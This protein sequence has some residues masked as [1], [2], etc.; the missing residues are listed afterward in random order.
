[1]KQMRVQVRQEQDRVERLED[2]V[3]LPYSIG[4]LCVSRHAQVSHPKSFKS[5]FMILTQ[6]FN[7]WQNLRSTCFA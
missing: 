3:R 6:W 7:A 2:K 5:R 1:M 4:C